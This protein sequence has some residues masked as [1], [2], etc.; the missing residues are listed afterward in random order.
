MIEHLPHPSDRELD[1]FTDLWEASVRAT[2]RFL[3]EEEILRYRTIV[4]REA[5]PAARLHV[6]RDAAGRFTAFLGME[7]DK[8]EMLFV[9][10]TQR[11]RGY[12][13]R[14]VEYAVARCGA[15]R[16]DVNEEN[17]Q[18]RGFYARMG[19]R[20]V[21]RDALDGWGMPHPILHLEL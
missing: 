9:D 7:E 20:V 2:H 5:L 10:A 4:R 13:R 16:V 14:L 21:R 3:A 11:G 1:A 8:I 15:R 18:A 6:A 17:T 12:G 19:F